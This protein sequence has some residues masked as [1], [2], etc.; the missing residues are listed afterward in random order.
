MKITLAFV[1]VVEFCYKIPYGILLASYI[2]SSQNNKIVVFMKL[3]MASFIGGAKR[4]FDN[5]RGCPK[6]K[7]FGPW[8]D[9][10]NGNPHCRFT[11]RAFSCLLAYLFPYRRSC[12]YTMQSSSLLSPLYRLQL[13][14]DLQRTVSDHI[15]LVRVLIHSLFCF[16]SLYSRFENGFSLRVLPLICSLVI[17]GSIWFERCLYSEIRE[18]VYVYWDCN[19]IFPDSVVSHFCQNSTWT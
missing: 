18:W 1:Q 10:Q 17:M 19:R 3:Q 11:W 9:S 8:V 12:L 6:R 7:C 14:W 13:P 2:K 4:S 15:A 5:P 16:L